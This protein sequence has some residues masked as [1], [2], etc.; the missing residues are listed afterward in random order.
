MSHANYIAAIHGFP[1]FPMNGIL[2]PK[3]DARWRL[4]IFLR[5]DSVALLG[6]QGSDASTSTKNASWR[7]SQT[8]ASAL[9]LELAVTKLSP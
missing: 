8:G 4:F 1:G 7:M 6:N 3:L 9:T 2:N 5:Y